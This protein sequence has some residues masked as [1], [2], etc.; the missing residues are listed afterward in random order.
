[1]AYPKV[2]LYRNLNDNKLDAQLSLIEMESEKDYVSL[3]VKFV[4]TNY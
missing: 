3:P 1:M 4:H 2:V